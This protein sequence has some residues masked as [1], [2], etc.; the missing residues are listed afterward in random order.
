MVVDAAVVHVVGA[1]VACVG[2][3]AGDVGCFLVQSFL[4]WYP[5]LRAL[6]VP[7]ISAF[8]R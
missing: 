3:G 5:T 8:R 4:R 2:V 1:F 7:V 6:M